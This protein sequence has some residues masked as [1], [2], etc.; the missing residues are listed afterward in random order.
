MKKDEIIW[1]NEV[2]APLSSGKPAFE[3]VVVFTTGNQGS[4]Q[5][6][7]RVMEQLSQVQLL[8]KP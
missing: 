5:L 1:K 2:Q 8:G 4:K 3:P 6:V 7:G